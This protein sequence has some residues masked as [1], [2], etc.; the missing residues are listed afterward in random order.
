MAV[1]AI[2]PKFPKLLSVGRKLAVS[3]IKDGVLQPSRIRSVAD[4]NR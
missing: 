4:C 3:A 1:P 2:V